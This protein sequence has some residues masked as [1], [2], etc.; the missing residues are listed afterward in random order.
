MEQPSPVKKEMT[1][2]NIK[3]NLNSE[4][5]FFKNEILGELRMLENK[6]LK[7]LEQKTDTSHKKMV[8]LETNYDTL[9]KKI[10]SMSNFYSENTTMKDKLENLFKAKTS[11]E[12][13]IYIH[14]YKLS[15][16][17][18]DLVTAINKYDKI[19]E[20]SIL[21]PGLIGYSSSKFNTFHNFIDYVML[22]IN[23][24]NHFKDKT[25]GLDLKQYKNKLETT[26]DGFK[27]QTEEIITNNKVYTSKLIKNLEN[28]FR[29]DFELYDQKLFNLKIKNTEQVM[30]LEKLT[31]KLIN[32]L[33]SITD[34]KN[35]IE[36][37]YEAS[38]QIL[39]WHYIYTEN[40]MNQCVKDYDD[41]KKRMNL[42]IE[43]LKGFKGGNNPNLPEILRELSNLEEN[44]KE[45][46]KKIKAESL[47]KKYIVGE[48]NMEQISQLSKKSSSK[49]ASNEGKNIIKNIFEDNN[50]S[51][52]NYSKNS[53][54]G[55]MNTRSVIKYNSNKIIFNKDR[56]SES[57][58]NN[59]NIFASQRISF[60]KRSQEFI[61]KLSNSINIKTLKPNNSDVNDKRLSLTKMSSTFFNER[62]L[63]RLNE[64]KIELS[65]RSQLLEIKSNKNIFDE[66]NSLDNDIQQKSSL[67]N[68]PQKNNI[69]NNKIIHAIRESESE[70]KNDFNKQENDIKEN[71]IKEEPK[72]I[73]IK[74]DDNN[75]YLIQTK[76]KEKENNIKDKKENTKVKK[77]GNININNNINEKEEK[78]KDINELSISP[79]VNDTQKEI[80]DL[81]GQ[82]ILSTITENN[83][84]TPRGEEDK[85]KSE[86][87]INRQ[88]EQNKNINN[89]KIKNVKNN[90]EIKELKEEKKLLKKKEKNI[91]K[92]RNDEDKENN[93]KF[94]FTNNENNIINEDYSNIRNV[95]LPS[96]K[97]FQETNND[98]NF[99]LE[100]EN[101]SPEKNI[102]EYSPDTFNINSE[103]KMVL[104][105][106]L[107]GDRNALNSFKLKK[108]VDDIKMPKIPNSEYERRKKNTRSS[109]RNITSTKSRTSKDIKSATNI[110]FY[111]SNKNNVQLNN[112]NK[113]D[114]IENL[115]ENNLEEFFNDFVGNTDINNI[116]PLLPNT[117]QINIDKPSKLNIVHIPGIV[118]SQRNIKKEYSNDALK[119]IAALRKIKYENDLN[120]NNRNRINKSNE[121]LRERNQFGKFK[122]NNKL[123]RTYEGFNF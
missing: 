82:T 86:D 83:V 57:K 25:M 48:M 109:G 16:I 66:K 10:F 5:L 103:S 23:Q 2:I 42:I 102:Q 69:Y 1:N 33:E 94:N 116:N 74:K 121:N 112:D 54:F 34:M 46:S 101:K 44:T 95:H 60:P 32:D 81:E 19:I 118:N 72:E 63:S 65:P 107:K 105:K 71:D 17:A 49:L 59:T 77:E 13:T 113:F 27:K 104:H 7:K 85:E 120:D 87:E 52:S 97:T 38:I 29:N 50:N 79:R 110:N 41:I 115:F 70:Y 51:S 20:K 3:P 117:Q 26:I 22:N 111:N 89:K 47:L 31:T 9:N 100:I 14:E 96:D 78:N 61:G 12:E 39:R 106:L 119:R 24:L 93:I 15:S 84:I 122:M 40:R 91:I 37:S 58:T 90:F 28:K 68:K 4:L 98:N 73:T 80:S 123:M 99:H 35:K 21:Y 88:L 76:E 92:D 30:G 6:L 45:H 11:I 62:K 53:R 56:N 43:A 67:L 108:N 8:Q 75:T 36:K 114:I 55:K 64:Q 18:K